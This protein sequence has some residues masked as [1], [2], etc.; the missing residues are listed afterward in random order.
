M[1]PA[2]ELTKEMKLR[3]QIRCSSALLAFDIGY[4]VGRSHYL[5]TPKFP[6]AQVRGQTDVIQH[7]VIHNQVCG[8][9]NLEDINEPTFYRLTSPSN[10][11]SPHPGITMVKLYGFPLSTCTRLVALVCKEKEIPYE[12]IS[13]NLAKGEQ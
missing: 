13:V 4:Y 10:S 2:L 3:S 12:L 9:F 7:L 11:I 1:R 8:A 6:S 5:A